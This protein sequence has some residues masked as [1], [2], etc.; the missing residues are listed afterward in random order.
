MLFLLKEGRAFFLVL[1]ITKND[2]V[3]N[4]LK[5]VSKNDKLFLVICRRKVL[6]Y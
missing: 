2:I 4:I 3:I 1:V 5:K 6:K